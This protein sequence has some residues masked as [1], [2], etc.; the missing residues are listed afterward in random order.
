MNTLCVA[1]RVRVSQLR[2][3]HV[4]NIV[5]GLAPGYLLENFNQ[6]NNTRGV[7]NLN[8][9][10]PRPRVGTYNSSNFYYHAILDWNSLPL[11][12]KSANNKTGFKSMV[13]AH[14]AQ[15]AQRRENSEFS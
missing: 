2:L 9:N 13:K 4:F 15:E 14:L 1:D 7:S 5:H 11:E 3:N 10:V 8:F 6:N 12:V